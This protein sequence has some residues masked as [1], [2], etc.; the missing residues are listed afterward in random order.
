MIPSGAPQH[1]TLDTSSKQTQEGQWLIFVFASPEQ[2]GA[3]EVRRCD[4]GRVRLAAAFPS[5]WGTSPSMWQELQSIL[6]SH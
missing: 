4:Q 1:Q 3:Q 5:G 6:N 2:T